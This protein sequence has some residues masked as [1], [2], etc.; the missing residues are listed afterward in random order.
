VRP[1]TKGIGPEE[2]QRAKGERDRP[3]VVCPE[4]ATTELCELG[5]RKRSVRHC[6]PQRIEVDT[7]ALAPPSFRFD[8]RRDDVRELGS[9]DDVQRRAKAAGFDDRWI[10]R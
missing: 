10:R 6:R 9:H 4:H 2:R 8:V 7:E 1:R 5:I 3:L